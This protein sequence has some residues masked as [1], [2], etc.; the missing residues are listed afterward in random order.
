MRPRGEQIQEGITPPG[1]GAKSRGFSAIR[2]LPWWGRPPG[3]GA[4]ITL[5]FREER[6]PG[7]K[8]RQGI[9]FRVPPGF[10]ANPTRVRRNSASLNSAAILSRG[11]HHQRKLML[12]EHSIIVRTRAVD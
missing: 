9:V 3:F 7:E 10:G 12:D 11:E 8:G 6:T 2:A 4:M 5:L 1:F